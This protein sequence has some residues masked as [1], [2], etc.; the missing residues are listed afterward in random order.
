MKFWRKAVQVID[1][2]D[3]TKPLFLYL[4]Y[5]APHGPINRPPEK[6]RNLFRSKVAKSIHYDEG[7]FNRAST[8][9]VGW[10]TEWGGW[11]FAIFAFCLQALDTG[12]GSVVD[13]L[14]ANGLFDNSIVVFS[15]DNGGAILDSSNLPLRG[16]KEQLYEGGVRGVGFVSS[17]LLRNTG[18]ESKK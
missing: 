4:A 17:P 9:L 2:H 3:K 6:Y 15:T 1:S 12:V 5:Q 16:N 14:K 13:A 11:K 18:I 8:I 7:R 10:T